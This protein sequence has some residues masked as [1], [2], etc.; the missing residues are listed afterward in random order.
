MLT[1][2]TKIKEK[3][4]GKKVSA[5]LVAVVVHAVIIFVAMLIAVLPSAKEEPEIVAQVVAPVVQTE[6]KLEKKQVVKQAKEASA[7][8]A[9]SPIAK[10]IRSNSIA[11][12]ATPEV[13]K[14]SD[15]PIGVG[16]GDFGSGFGSGGGG[17]GGMG[18]GASFFGG[19][20][21]GNR[22]LF[23]ID[24]SGSMTEQQV[25]LR[26][27]ELKR[28]LRALKGVEYQ[29]LLFAGGAYYAEK[30]W[31]LTSS[32]TP[33]TN[34][35]KD[36]QGKE[37]EFEPKSGAGWDN[38][39]FRGASSRLPTTKWLKASSS[40]VKRTMDAVEDNRLFGGTDW[41]LALEIAHLMEPPPDAIFFMSD[42]TGG[43]DPRPILTVNRRRGKPTINT[44]AMQTKAG[45]REFAEIAKGTG[46]KFTLV[47]KNGKSIDG[48]EYM[49][50]PG[51]F[52]RYLQ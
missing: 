12:I 10:M 39:D 32:G 44:I 30:G 51:R 24:H 4:G 23:V 25:D 9:A 48:D 38:Y 43:N 46:G 2:D 27:N 22:F 34:T 3:K 5:L 26:N 35:V 37:Y 52:A 14:F 16:E 11:K 28:A 40:N 15:G 21:T 17:G 29:V 49:K 13:T 8:A 41:G 6:I 20:S 36:P 47:G 33:P 45:A 18:L 7:S 31:S 1:T 42:G 19:K 50:N